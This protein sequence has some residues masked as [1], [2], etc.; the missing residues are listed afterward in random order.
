MRMVQ[1]GYPLSWVARLTSTSCG[2]IPLTAS[3]SAR[4][5]WPA[6]TRALARLMMANVGSLIHLLRG[7][8][9][10][11]QSMSGSGKAGWP[12]NALEQMIP[13]Q[14]LSG[15]D[16]RTGAPQS[17]GGQPGAHGL[18]GPQKILPPYQRPHGRL[19][20]VAANDPATARRRRLQ[21]PLGARLRVAGQFLA[22]VLPGT[23]DCLPAAGWASSTG[24]SPW[25]RH[26]SPWTRHGLARRLCCRTPSSLLQFVVII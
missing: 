12:A 16:A 14:A 23:V 3:R 25:T 7:D 17:G 15:S 4:W 5:G 18:P 6:D 26:G 1:R 11:S 13:N 9:V 8:V 20:V 19:D 22:G 21:D 24:S 2:S 10:T